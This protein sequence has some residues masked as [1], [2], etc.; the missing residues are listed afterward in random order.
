MSSVDASRVPLVCA[1]LG[2]LI[3]DHRREMSFIRDLDRTLIQCRVEIP[4]ARESPVL[5]LAGLRL[6]KFLRRRALRPVSAR[7]APSAPGRPCRARSG[8]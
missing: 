5:L 4:A 7:L 8:V 6:G 2:V 3:H 1:V